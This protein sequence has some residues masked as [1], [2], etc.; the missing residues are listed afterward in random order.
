MSLL[1]FIKPVLKPNGR[2]GSSGL[3]VILSNTLATYIL[4][5]SPIY[6]DD[7]GGALGLC[8]IRKSPEA[9]EMF[10]GNGW[11]L[12]PPDRSSNPRRTSPSQRATAP[13]FLRAARSRA[14]LVSWAFFL[15]PRRKQP[16][17][18]RR[19]GCPSREPDKQLIGRS[20][21]RSCAQ[22]KSGGGGGTLLG[23]MLR[24]QGA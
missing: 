24:A 16:R 14:G 4:M 6:Q 13:L 2:F 11:P 18:P 7:R 19:L 17:T 5:P 8:V 3:E 12:E 15:S 22:P 23:S 21:T 10:S 1:I 9:R 20:W